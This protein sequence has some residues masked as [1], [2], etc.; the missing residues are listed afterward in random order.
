[1][2]RGQVNICGLGHS[3]VLSPSIGV[4]GVVLKVNCVRQFKI[5]RSWL[6]ERLEHKALSQVGSGYLL[7]QMDL[8]KSLCTF[9]MN[10]LTISF[11][12]LARACWM[13]IQWLIICP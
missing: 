13:P 3:I 4:C 11:G 8:K 7:L 5:N 9:C 12:I 6:C 1:M 2:L 10:S